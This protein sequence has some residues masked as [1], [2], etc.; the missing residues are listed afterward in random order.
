MIGCRS[1][2]L[3][4]SVRMGTC[5]NI[6]KLLMYAFLLLFFVLLRSFHLYFCTLSFT[7]WV[8]S[9]LCYVDICLNSLYKMG[10]PVLKIYENYGLKWS[11]LCV[12]LSFWVLV[13]L[14]IVF[15]LFHRHQQQ[16]LL[17]QLVTQWLLRPNIHLEMLVALLGN[18]RA[19]LYVISCIVY[20]AIMLICL[21]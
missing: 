9:L 20:Q 1:K 12:S 11:I 15:Q 6:C 5:T 2:C 18:F 16:Q 10:C 4:S 13:C 14:L 8:A 19:T 7:F 17:M 21:V 3:S